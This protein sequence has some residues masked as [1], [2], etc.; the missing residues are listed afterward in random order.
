M[1]RGLSGRRAAIGITAR[2][3]RESTVIA[4]ISTFIRRRSVPKLVAESIITGPMHAMALAPHAA[5]TVPPLSRPCRRWMA[6]VQC[7][8]TITAAMPRCRTSA[9]AAAAACAAA[10]TRSPAPPPARSPACA[11]HIR[12]CLAHLPTSSTQSKR[13]RYRRSCPPVSLTLG[14]RCPRRAAAR[15]DLRV[16]T[17]CPATI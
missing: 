12:S 16:T 8:H 9:H 11:H 14:G 17:T 7:H 13:V 3:N 15:R 2:T 4:K 5:A 1:P 10:S 6:C